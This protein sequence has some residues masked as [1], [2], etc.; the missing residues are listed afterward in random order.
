VNGGPFAKLH[1][2]SPAVALTLILEQTDHSCVSDSH[3][4][5]ENTI[6]TVSSDEGYNK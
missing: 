6:G 4:H 5:G 2:T 1:L 3:S